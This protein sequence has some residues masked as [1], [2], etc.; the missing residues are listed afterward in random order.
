MRETLANDLIVLLRPHVVRLPPAEMAPTLTLL[1]GPEE[2][3]VS[4][5]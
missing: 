1:H 5:F 2:R 4:G 3:P